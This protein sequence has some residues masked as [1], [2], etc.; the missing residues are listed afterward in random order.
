MAVKI[1][2]SR[3]GKKDYAFFHIVVADSRV[4]RDSRIIEQIGH[5]N[6]NTNPATIYL[7]GENALNWLNKGAEPT[8]TVR[9][10]SSY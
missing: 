1:R 6:H 7:D 2:L 5:Y 9:P 3:R 10:I 4:P 8:N